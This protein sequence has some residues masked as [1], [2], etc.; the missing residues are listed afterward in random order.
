MIFEKFVSF[1]LRFLCKWSVSKYSGITQ[2]PCCFS[3]KLSLL[4]SSSLTLSYFTLKFDLLHQSLYG[5]KYFMSLVRWTLS[6]LWLLFKVFIPDKWREL[7]L[8]CILSIQRVNIY[9]LTLSNNLLQFTCIFKM[10]MPFVGC[11]F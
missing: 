9:T 3:L 4:C 5:P 8:E 1:Y 2:L 11:I 6:A 10:Q 7:Y